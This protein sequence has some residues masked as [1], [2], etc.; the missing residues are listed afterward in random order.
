MRR[1]RLV[2]ALSVVMLAVGLLAGTTLIAVT[3]WGDL[4][5]T[6]FSPGIQYDAKLRG[7]RCPVLITPKQTETIR[8][9]I[10]NTIDRSTNLFIRARTSEGYIT[11]IR[12]EQR[13]LPLDP[14]E[15]QWVEWTISAD[16]AAFGRLVLFKVTVTGGYP[17]PARQ[18]TCG[19]VR[20]N[21]TL[22]T[23]EQLH[24]LGLIVSLVCCIGAAVLQIRS[25]PQ[26]LGPGVQ[27]TRAMIWLAASILVGIVVSF[28]GWW[29]A[30]AVSLVVIL[31]TV[32]VTLGHLVS[33]SPQ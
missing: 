28:L 23:G 21:T 25:D 19:I 24:A 16:D 1:S 6:L 5:A 10:K 9:R 30:G 17:L 31:L 4:E 15:A 12:E 33:N 13:E 3:V 26:K 18:G 32:G 7:L 20:I 29:I 22:L 27:L 8:A 2:R 11:L 14:G